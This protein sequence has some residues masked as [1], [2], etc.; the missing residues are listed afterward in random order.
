MGKKLILTS[1]RRQS[2]GFLTAYLFLISPALYSSPLAEL[3]INQAGYILGLPKT[4]VLMAGSE[5]PARIR[6]R[7]VDA[8]A[9]ATVFNGSTS[10]SHHRW[11]DAYSQ[12]YAIDLSSVDKPGRYVIQVELPV[13]VISSEFLIGTAP[14]LLHHLLAN[15]RFFF[16][17][18][19]DG[20]HINPAILNREP[21]HLFD[22]SAEVYARP[23]DPRLPDIGHSLGYSVDAAG[24]WFDAGDYMKFVESA[25]FTDAVLLF[26]VRG[27]PDLLGLGGSADFFTEA[28]FGLDWLLKMWD[29]ERRILYYQV[30]LAEGNRDQTIMGDHDL[31]RVPEKD[32][33]PAFI[34]I[35]NELA[36]GGRQHHGHEPLYFVCHRPV[37]R[38]GPPGSRISP[39]LAGRLAAD[40][41]LGCQ[42]YLKSDPNFAA[43]CLRAAVQV[44]ALAATDMKNSADLVTTTPHSFYSEDEWRDDMELGA[45]E[46]A[47]A[48]SAERREADA[49]KYLVK[50]G[51]WAYR[52]DNDEQVVQ[53]SLNL[54]DVS[55]LANY[56]LYR[57]IS[58]QKNPGAYGVEPDDL[59]THF[60]DELQDADKVRSQ[61]PFGLALKLKSGDPVPRALGL[62][63]EAS[64][65]HEIADEDTYLSMASSQVDWV[66]GENAWGM[67][68]IVGAGSHFPHFLHHQIANLSGR[69]DGTPPILLG[70]VVDGPQSN[71][72]IG[73]VDG[74]RLPP[75]PNENP[76]SRYDEAGMRFLDDVRSDKTVEPSDDYAALSVLLFAR[77]SKGHF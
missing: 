43:R 35:Q 49:Q 41:A 4:A 55:S 68:F 45:V 46:I 50:A 19:R 48:C 58:T 31:W 66:L 36:D 22:H 11:N 29:P 47:N 21:S 17:A 44:Y 5:T 15:A 57:S 61:N 54:Y 40:Y 18:Q 16:Q 75:H 74:M 56:D 42:V 32:E 10:T 59:L 27:A 62:A 1:S 13:P 67:S 9:G 8:A 33:D 14:S 70:A 39:N 34:R 37:F 2:A 60:Q 71:I 6:F 72:K 20:A 28:R 65:Y 69:L 25:S 64:L 77:W 7:V 38:V 3:R 73:R 26:A 53:D 23:S 63:I 52:Y 24:G 76:Y 12:T 30:G 51:H